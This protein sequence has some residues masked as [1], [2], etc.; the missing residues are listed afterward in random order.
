VPLYG[1]L[2]WSFRCFILWDFGVTSLPDSKKKDCKHV[3]SPY[4][5][6]K[7][8][9]TINLIFRYLLNILAK[10]EAKSSFNF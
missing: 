5:N 6:K 10:K 8:Q 4:N 3:Q 1:F 7:K 9:L 2:L